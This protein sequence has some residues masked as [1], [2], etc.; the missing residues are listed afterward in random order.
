[1][2]ALKP[3]ARKPPDRATVADEP[4]NPG[5]VMSRSSQPGELTGDY[6]IDPAHSRLGFVTRHAMVTKV[7]G[8]FSDVEG[9]IHLDEASPRDSTATVRIKTASI[10]TAQQQRDDHL[11]SAD[12]FD[13]ETYPEIV[14]RITAIEP[15]G[16]DLYAVSGELTIRDVAKPLTFDLEF[17][18][19]AH[20]PMGNTRAGFEGSTQI[21]RKDWGLTWNA[22][23]DSGGF[24]VSEKVT[25]ELD[26]SAIKQ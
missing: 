11:R 17:T 13:V 12:F 6:T 20:D 3:G 15:K 2:A 19:L 8:Q 4:S 1:M 22:A 25:L 21:N 9:H 24:L 7:R 26:I 16:G 14:F 5:A 23:M 10:D 18:G